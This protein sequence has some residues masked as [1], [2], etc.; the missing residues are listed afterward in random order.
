MSLGIFLVAGTGAPHPSAA[1]LHC[2]ISALVGG[3]CGSCRGRK[4]SCT[5]AHAVGA[6]LGFR[7]Q[8]RRAVAVWTPPR[9]ALL[10]VKCCQHVSA[11][12][13]NLSLFPL[14]C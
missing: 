4:A 13:G 2:P 9:W 10:L 8:L 6:W 3:G 5:S 7:G 14:L 12:D 1:G 11:F